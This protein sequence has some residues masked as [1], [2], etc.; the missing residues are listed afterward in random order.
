MEAQTLSIYELLNMK[1][2]IGPLTSLAVDE[3]ETNQ[4]TIGFSFSAILTEDNGKLI[5]NF[6][7]TFNADINLNQNQYLSLAKQAVITYA[8]TFHQRSL[9]VNDIRSVILQ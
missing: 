4:Y 5:E 1:A 6:P 9:S 2:I 7:L 3:V 8:Q